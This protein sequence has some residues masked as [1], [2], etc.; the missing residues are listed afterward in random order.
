MVNK[1]DDLGVPLTAQAKGRPCSPQ[2]RKPVWAPVGYSFSFGSFGDFQRVF[3][4]DPQKTRNN[5]NKLG[6]L[7]NKSSMNHG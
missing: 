2:Q 4:G 7:L 6:C 3:T 5:G 1:L